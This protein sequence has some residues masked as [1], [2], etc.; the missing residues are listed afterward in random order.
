MS[1][2]GAVAEKWPAFS[3]AVGVGID[4]DVGVG[5]GVKGVTNAGAGGGVPTAS[6]RFKL[7]LAKK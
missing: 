1:Q 2:H 5:V 3:K 4:I 6:Q 7:Q